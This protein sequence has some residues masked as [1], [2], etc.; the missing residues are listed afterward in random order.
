MRMRHVVL[1]VAGLVLFEGSRVPAKRRMI[2]PIE[3][4]V[5]RAANNAADGIRMPVRAV[6]QAG[7][8]ATVPSIAAL[9][10]LTGRRRVAMEV[11]LAGT[12][13]WLLA[14]SAKPLVGRPRPGR[15]LGDVRTRERIGGDL[16][17]VSGHT[18]VSTTLALTLSPGV[19][20]V[21]RPLLAGVAAATAFGRMYVGAHLP[22]DL[23]GGVGLGMMIAA[24]VKA[25]GEWPS[26]APR[27]VTV[28]GSR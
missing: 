28:P 14:K 17:W 5:F 9:L 22:L 1:A 24:A 4:W 16:G 7:T 2:H 27:G 12:T 11:A 13:A 10:A 18:A 20:L 3:E 19:P 25:A 15:V 23:V 26:G 8:F 6:M 21:A